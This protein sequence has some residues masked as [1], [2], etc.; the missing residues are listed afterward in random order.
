MSCGDNAGNTYAVATTFFDTTSF[1]QIG[2]CYATNIT[3]AATTVTATFGGSSVANRRIIAHEYSGIVTPNGSAVDA[4][5]AAAASA[6]TATDAV[7]SGNGTTTVQNALVFGAVANVSATSA[8]TA[9][10]NFTQR[11]SLNGKDFATQDRTLAS[12]GSVASTQTF[13]TN[14][15]RYLAAMVAF[16]PEAISGTVTDTFNNSMFT[17]S[18]TGDASFKGAASTAAFRVLNASDV[19]QFSVD[20]SNSRVYI[21]NP[22]A[23]TTGALLVLDVKTDAGDPTGVE[24]GMYYNRNTG[25]FRCYTTAWSDCAPRNLKKTTGT[26]T[27][28]SATLATIDGLTFTAPANTDYTFNCSIIFFT[29]TAAT[30]LNLGFAVPTGSTIFAEA[31]I[32]AAASGVDGSFQAHWNQAAVVAGPGTSPGISST[33]IATVEGVLRTSANSGTFSVQFARGGS[34]TLSLVQASNCR[35]S[36]M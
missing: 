30:G 34:G 17:L 6:T 22:T 33:A 32:P 31:S 26:Q 29:S 25:T 1:R 27:S 36:Q 8:I 3:G 5:A 18:Q 35:I 7:T 16:K 9:G 24:G 2:I 15:N 12:P 28:A 23:D 14:G 21:G 13:G 11:N 10:T 20:T 19:P 4:T